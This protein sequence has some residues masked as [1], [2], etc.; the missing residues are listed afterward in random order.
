[1]VP[2]AYVRLDALPLTP[3]GKLDRKALPAPDGDAYVT[4]GYE[5]PQGEIEESAGGDLVGGAEGRARRTKRQLLRAGRALAAGGAAGVAGARVR[6][7]WTWPWRIC[8]RIR[9]CASW[10]RRWVGA[11]VDELPPIVAVPRG[12]RLPLS[13]AQQRLWFLSQ[14]EGASGAYHLSGRLRLVGALDRA[15][16]APRA[17]PDRGAA[18]GVAHALRAGGRPA[19]R[20]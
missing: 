11:P 20:R 8:S 18:R 15:A 1:M 7:A 12:G 6:S 2:A 13:L 17:R 16:L 5:A 4:G 9:C 14:L 10:R 19:R 3:N